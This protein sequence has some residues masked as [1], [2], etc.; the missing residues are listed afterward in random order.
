M[1]AVVGQV[2]IDTSREEEARKLLDE[3]V[4]PTSK[5]L[6][7]FEGGYWA[8]ALESDAGHS[9]LLFDTEENARAAAARMAEGPP[10]GG[11]TSFVSATVC[12]VI[13]QA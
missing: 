5:G 6:A 4:L 13:A 8:R 9:I 7:G 2:R 12:E 1:H 3:F 10:P 11:P